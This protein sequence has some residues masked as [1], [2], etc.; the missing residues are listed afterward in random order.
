MRTALSEPVRITAVLTHPVQYMA[1]WFRHIAA[2]CPE[3]DLTV[4]YGAIPSAEQQGVGFD[5]AFT[6]DVPVTDGYRFTVCGDAAGRRFDSDSFFGLDVRDIGR[7]IQETAADVVMLAGWHSAMQVRALRE[8]RR[9]G[10]PVLYRGDST[11]F[12]GRRG[13]ARPAWELKTRYFLRRFSGYLSVGR[14]ATEYL[15]HFGVPEA[16]IARSPHCVDNDAFAAAAARE[17]SPERRQ[18]H[19]AAIGAHEDDLVVLFAGKFQERKRP[20]DAV[21]A[22][23]ALGSGAVLM[24]AGDGPLAAS[25]RAEAVRRGVRLAW[26]GFLNQSQL[27]AAFAAADCVLVPSAWESW[28]LIVNE[29]LASGVPCVVTDGVAAA[30]D[31]IVE[32]RTGY[33]VPVGDVAAIAARL[34]DVHRARQHGEDL[35]AACQQ[36]VATCSIEAAT[37]GLALAARR[38]VTG[39]SPVGE[40][41]RG[42]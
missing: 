32:G 34:R 39:T 20:L 5:R 9:A 17:R 8:C 35:A 10:I 4:L 40:R 37:N 2:N 38:A 3:I 29:A 11:L 19:R 23:A 28:G 21:R 26:R 25:A 30:P 36:A 22:V 31:L 6:W 14:H 27:P 15:R 41:V 1:P 13:L 7:R 33:V 24:T 12:S 42:A 18:Q 16:L